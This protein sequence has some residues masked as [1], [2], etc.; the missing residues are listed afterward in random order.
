MSDVNLA[1][2]L[3]F[4]KRHLDKPAY[5]GPDFALSYAELD[6]AVRRQAAWMTMQEVAP[7]ERIVIALD[8][9][10]DLAVIFFASLAVGALP[11]VVS[12]KLDTAPLRHILGD[13]EPLM[14]YGKA[15]Q[16]DTI[17]AA[18][19]GLATRPQAFLLE[20]GWYRTLLARRVGAPRA[21]AAALAG[22]AFDE[23][24]DEALEEAAEQ[25]WDAAVLRDRHAPALIQ[26]TSG[27]TG[28]AKGVTHSAASVLACCAAVTGQLGL[29][30]DDVLYSV[31]KSFFGFGMG[32]SLFFPLH[33]GAS[34]VLDAAWPNAAQVEANLRRFR[35]TVL[36]AVPTL[37]RMLLDNGF[38]PDD[39]PLRLAFSAGAPLAGNTGARW[40][41]R[42]GFDLHDGIGATELCHVFATSYPDSLRRGSLGRLLAGCEARIVDEA[43]HEV[44]PGETG[45]LVV[46]S[47][48]VS[49]GYWRRPQD[50]AARF[51]GGWYRTGD[52]FSRD[53]DGF[54][55]FHGRE[56]DRFKV[57]GR[58]VVPAE[59]EALLVAHAPQLGDCF[60]VP[61]REPNGEDRPVLC[62]HG[63]H[64]G[65]A[66]RQVL[67][68]LHR[69]DG[70][71]RPVRLLPVDELPLTP[72][73]KPNRR[74][75]AQLASRALQDG[76]GINLVE[77]STC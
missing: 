76:T 54:L 72:N 9:G 73:G 62:L 77:E 22:D 10:P 25:E 5:I 57:F 64:G 31:P 45:V 2:A 34:A 26:Y 39:S 55:Y 15:V 4:N 74:A 51:H 58:W 66:A 68:V 36:F 41:E 56:D 21:P 23:S 17:R 18:I 61:G 19:D 40:R 13:A 44:R 29:S 67:A 16:A 27:T 65:H 49:P 42:F 46:K 1:A 38:G 32:N 35:P 14:V 43:G 59:I 50:D 3:L 63:Q 75:L 52:L 71:K 69:L 53:A 37:Y 30:A 33:L 11:V 70:Y 60:V 47:P 20:A 7:G 12:S 6:R 28:L 24:S 8:D 48:A